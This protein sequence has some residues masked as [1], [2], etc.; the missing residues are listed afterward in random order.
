MYSEVSTP[1]YSSIQLD[2]PLFICHTQPRVF[3]KNILSDDIIQK[4][5]YDEAYLILSEDGEYTTWDSFARKVQDLNLSHK[6]TVITTANAYFSMKPNSLT[7]VQNPFKTIYFNSMFLNTLKYFEPVPQTPVS[8]HFKCLSLR[9]KYL[10]RYFY[11]LIRKNNL[12]DKGIVSHNKIVY[13]ENVDLNDK[14]FISSLKSYLSETEYAEFEKITNEVL[15][16][17]IDPDMAKQHINIFK[18]GR[19][20]TPTLATGVDVIHEST[21]D[22]GINFTSEKTLKVI[23]NKDIFLLLGNYGSLHFLRSLGFKTFNHIFDESYDMIRDS[24]SRAN[25]V[26]SELKKFCSLSLDEVIKIKNDNQ[27]ILDYNYNHLVY[28]LDLTF[29]LKHKVESYFKG[30]NNGRN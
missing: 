28:N 16:L 17:D 9:D 23:L 11:Y 30:E 19:F 7:R 10:R 20:F 22:L 26:M 21:T 13:D 8:K 18:Y 15:S 14:N 6:N 27:N 29:N 25:A 1:V 3:D 12:L 5:N 24:V 4:I 2:K